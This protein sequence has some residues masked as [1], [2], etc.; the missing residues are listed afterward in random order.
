MAQLSMTLK[1]EWNLFKR[2]W[3]TT[4]RRKTILSKDD[5]EDFN[6]FDSFISSEIWNNKEWISS[7]KTILLF[8]NGY[9]KV[10]I[11]AKSGVVRVYY[12]PFRVTFKNFRWKKSVSFLIE[13]II[14]KL[15]DCF[16]KSKPD[17]E[18]VEFN[19]QTEDIYRKYRDNDN[20]YNND[21]NNNNNNNDNNEDDLK[22][23]EVYDQEDDDENDDG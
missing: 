6:H 14:V 5:E 1:E 18:K 7:V 10:K 16:I 19:R 12:S 9:G 21:N 2:T 13:P 15:V 4:T 17:I 3:I 8:R 20:T 22:A 11:F 23:D